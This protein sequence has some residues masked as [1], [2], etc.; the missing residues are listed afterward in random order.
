M[1]SKQEIKKLNNILE[2]KNNENLKLKRTVSDLKKNLF[3]LK[4]DYDKINS[5]FI[6]QKGLINKFKKQ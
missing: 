2:K 5:E 1:L 6:S 3:Y 4:N